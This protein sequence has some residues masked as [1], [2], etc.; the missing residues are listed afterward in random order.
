M[1]DTYMVEL[2]RQ[3]EDY[4]RLH[5]TMVAEYRELEQEFLSM[6]RLN[7]TGHGVELWLHRMQ[8]IQ[9]ILDKAGFERLEEKGRDDEMG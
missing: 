1:P 4:K 9:R 8:Q 6:Q 5:T 7:P 2:K 3:L